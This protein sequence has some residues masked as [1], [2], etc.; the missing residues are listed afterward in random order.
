MDVT[1]RSSDI[2]WRRRLREAWRWVIINAAA[3]GGLAAIGRG[4]WVW[5]H[6][7]CALVV[8]GG[9]LLAGAVAAVLRAPA[10]EHGPC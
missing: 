6:P 7:G 3:V 9:L 2:R 1:A 10:G 4:L 5:V 8:V